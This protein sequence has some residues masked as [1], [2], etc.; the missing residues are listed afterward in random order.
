MGITH[1][2]SPIAYSLTYEGTGLTSYFSFTVTPSEVQERLDIYLSKNLPC[3]TRSQ[4]RR[5][6]EESRVLL[7]HSPTKAGK[8]LKA[9]DLIEVTIP[10]PQPLEARPEKV[11]LKILYEDES[12]VV[13]DKPP[14]LI[15]HPGAGRQSGTLVNALL[16]H[17]KDLSG[18][19]GK[20]RPGIVHRL[21]KDTSGVLVVAKTDR[22]HEGLARQFKEH[23]VT[24]RYLT[25]VW[26]MV[27]DDAGVIDLPI[28][29]HPVHRKKMHVTPKGGRRALTHYKVLERF[30]PITLLEVTL[31][32]GRTHQVRV[33]LSSI[34][35]PVVG[36]SIY[37]WKTVPGGLPQRLKYRLK[38]LKRQ[39]LHAATLGFIHPV[40]GQY[41]EFAS[42]PAED[43]RKVVEVL[44]QIQE[45]LESLTP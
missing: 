25:L 13:V 30:G 22:A 2:L 38:E 33:H 44:K 3:L 31:K 5:L 7:N 24:R 32:T 43:M 35:H 21:D 34:H 42:D 39:A 28:G 36:D 20:L 40:S 26:G 17:C 18:I 16:Y 19:G 27:K 4:I 45:T 1:H 6:I 9:G 8:K 41:M 11:P 37:G 23:S 29:R 12:I 10:E 15:V 14:G